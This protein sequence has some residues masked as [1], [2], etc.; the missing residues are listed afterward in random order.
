MRGFCVACDKRLKGRQVYYC[1]ES[2]RKKYKR[3]AALYP[4]LAGMK[5]LST[6]FGRDV[7]A[8]GRDEAGIVVV[9]IISYNHHGKT[10]ESDGFAL[11]SQFGK[12][13]QQMALQTLRRL[14]V[15]WEFQIKS[16]DVQ[17]R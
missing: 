17:K 5:P 15:G 11:K 9:M 1:S 2:C 10:H 13:M 12:E 16:F 3:L 14:F 8:L 6:A 4:A 7:S